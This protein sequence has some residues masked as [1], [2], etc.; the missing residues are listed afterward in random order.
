MNPLIDEAISLS[1]PQLKLRSDPSTFTL[2]RND[3]PEDVSCFFARVTGGILF[4]HRFDD[5][6]IIGFEVADDFGQSINDIC[7]VSPGDA[8]FG[9]WDLC[10]VLFRSTMDFESV[11]GIDLNPRSY[12]RI[13]SCRIPFALSEHPQHGATVVARSFGEWL[14]FWVTNYHKAL[15]DWRSLAKEP[16]LGPVV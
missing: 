10:F 7:L 14:R 9:H 15:G 8:C 1:A 6:E 13:F 12:G 11:W 3:I 4:P 16:D 5:G 2:R